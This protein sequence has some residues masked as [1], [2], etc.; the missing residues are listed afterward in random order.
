[1]DFLVHHMLRSS[2]ARHPG[3]EALVHGSQRLTYRQVERAVNALG[4]GLKNAGIERGERVGI[5]VEP[6]VAQALS[7]F[8]VSCANAAFVPI[9]H[10]L[11]PEQVA[12]IVNDCRMKGLITTK[13]KLAALLPVLEQCPS[14]SFVVVLR[15]GDA[16][17]VPLPVYIFEDL[18]AVEPTSQNDLCIEK[19]LAA[20]LYTSGSTGR[21][22]RQKLG[23]VALPSPNFVGWRKPLKSG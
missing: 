7:I 21:P 23:S 11:F 3:K 15:E 13:S 8:A 19:D 14:L 20:I 22:R 4:Y 17:E 18:C 10:L 1:M 16:P 2:A 9:N 12:H 5:L 6:S